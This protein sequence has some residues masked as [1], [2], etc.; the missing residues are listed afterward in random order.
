MRGRSGQMGR[1]AQANPKHGSVGLAQ[2]Q[3]G[4]ACHAW[5]GTPAQR[6]RTRGGCGVESGRDAMSGRGE[7]RAWQRPGCDA[8]AAERGAES[9]RGTAGLGHDPGSTRPNN[10]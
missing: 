2:A 8:V 6:W 1:A 9:G 7:A 10:S 5:V 4:R 3:H